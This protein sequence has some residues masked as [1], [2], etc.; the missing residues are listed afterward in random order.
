MIT[1]LSRCLETPLLTVTTE[2][3]AAWLATPGWS[4]STRSTYRF[5]IRA[6]YGWLAGAGVL[7]DNPAAALPKVRVPLQPPRPVTNEMLALILSRAKAP[8]RLYF[9]L[10]AYAGLRCQEIAMLRTEDITE[11]AI[12]VRFGKGDQARQV[13]THP[14]IWA[15]VSLTPPGRILHLEIEYPPER[16]AAKMSALGFHYLARI[17][18]KGASM[19]RL[20]HW[21]ATNAYRQSHNLR[22]VQELLGHRSVA[23]TQRYTQVSSEER[24]LAVWA[25]PAVA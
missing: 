24:R 20:R 17:G 9:L 3:L 18:A 4:R 25:L 1:R 12:T 2:Q 7:A 6:Y 13:E 22:A 15:A 5:H 11:E 19:H 10:A 21:F 8:Y 16:A 14:L 23:T